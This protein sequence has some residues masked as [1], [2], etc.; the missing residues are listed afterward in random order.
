MSALLIERAFFNSIEP[1]DNVKVLLK[2]LLE[3]NK[4]KLKKNKDLIHILNIVS[5]TNKSLWLPEVKNKIENKWDDKYY[6][7][8]ID[9]LLT[10]SLYT[11]IYIEIYNYFTDNQ[12]EIIIEN[13]LSRE[14]TGKQSVLLG[15]FF[16]LLFKKE[17]LSVDDLD[18]FCDKH[19]ENF[20]GLIIS[21]LICISKNSKYTPMAKNYY[22]VLIS[23]TNL[24]TK[25]LML[26]YDLESIVS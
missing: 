15:T 6:D 25:I 10:Q 26:L 9:V 2:G 14:L 11:S 22:D 8:F 21:C 16:G 13:L 23:K 3:H 17:E 24:E 1:P 7:M 18:E 12:K 19:I 4:I 20:P 5:N